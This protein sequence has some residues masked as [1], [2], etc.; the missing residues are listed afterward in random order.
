MG[1]LKPAALGFDRGGDFLSALCS[2]ETQVGYCIPAQE[3]H[4][5]VRVG[6][7]E[8]HE[9]RGLEYLCWEKRLGELGLLS[10]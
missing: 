8:G 2:C 9:N 4:E 6:P 5:P 7:E 10:L 1:L 3:Q